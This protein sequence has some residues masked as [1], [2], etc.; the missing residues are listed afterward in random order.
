MTAKKS[1]ERKYLTVISIEGAIIT[2]IEPNGTIGRYHQ[3]GLQRVDAVDMRHYIHIGLVDQ[4][5]VN[6][7]ELP[8]NYSI[9]YEDP[10]L[11]GRALA[12]FKSKIR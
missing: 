10:E 3:R 4:R 6:F 8:R 9:S 2:L 7:K 12:T 5:W 11:M 1:T